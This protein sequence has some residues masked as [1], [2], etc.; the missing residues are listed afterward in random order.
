MKFLPFLISLYYHTF[1]SYIAQV[2]KQRYEEWSEQYSQTGQ[3]RSTSIVKRDKP[4]FSPG[5]A[6]SAVSL[7]EVEEGMKVALKA[8]KSTFFVDE[9][10]IS[11]FHDDNIMLM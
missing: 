5:V 2:T 11:K 7:G 9:N 6:E 1:P 3:S 10:M 4:V 8:V